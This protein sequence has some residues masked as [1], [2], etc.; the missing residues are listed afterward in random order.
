M[1]KSLPRQCGRGGVANCGGVGSTVDKDV[2]DQLQQDIENKFKAC[3]NPTYECTI[4]RIEGYDFCMRHI[5]RDPR[6]NFRQCSYSYSNNKKCTNALPKHDLKKD[7]NMT[8]LCFEHNRQVQLQK[9]HSS[10]GKLKQVDTNEALLNS[11][12]H[13][14]NVE[15]VPEKNEANYEQDEEIDVVSPHVTPFGKSLSIIVCISKNQKSI[16]C[17]CSSL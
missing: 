3:S 11:L 14:L 10:V 9:T 17:N 15:E 5:L 16:T 1:S 8:T 7:P 13:H 4:P 6:G 12:A 2:R